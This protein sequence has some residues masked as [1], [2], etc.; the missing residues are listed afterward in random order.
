MRSRGPAFDFWVA[1]QRGLDRTEMSLRELV[2]RSGVS[3]TTISR[4]QTAPARDRRKRREIVIKI[5]ETLNAALAERE[6]DA[7]PLFTGDDALQLA[8]LIESGEPRVSVRESILKSSEYDDRQKQAL[9]VLLD[10]LDAA[11]ARVNGTERTE[12]AG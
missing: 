6:P 3:A 1:V 10:G 7:E 9:L 8:G 12:R 4:L 2:D 5:A 11:N